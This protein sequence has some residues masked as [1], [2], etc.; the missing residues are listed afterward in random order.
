[1][2]NKKVNTY[3]VALATAVNMSPLYRG[4]DILLYLSPLIC[5]FDQFCVCAFSLTAGQH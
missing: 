5:S 4:G 3:Q 1:M 2:V